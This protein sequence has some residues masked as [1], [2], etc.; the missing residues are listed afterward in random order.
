MSSKTSHFSS[1]L[2][3]I[4]AVATLS[5]TPRAAVAHCD[6]LDG[7]VV[8]DAR[9]AL[10]KGDVTPALKWVKAEDEASLRAA[11][12]QTLAVRALS[13]EAKQLADT[14]FFETLVRLHRA[15][16]GAPYTGLKPAGSELSAAVKGADEALASGS[17]DALVKLVTGDVAGG[18]QERFSRA[19]EAARHAGHTVAAGREYVEAYVD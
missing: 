15:G 8:G 5:L 3:A 7:P 10:A 1:L 19:Q 11:F 17:V 4:L 12:A 16:E 14:F 6:T 18:I 9:A 2:A 13:P